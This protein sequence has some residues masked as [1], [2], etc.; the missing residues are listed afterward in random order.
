MPCPPPPP[1]PP[2]VTGDTAT[3]GKPKRPWVKPE[4]R[5]MKVNFTDSGSERDPSWSEHPKYAPPS[6]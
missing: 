6:S 4:I 5:K 2:P 1:P 3:D